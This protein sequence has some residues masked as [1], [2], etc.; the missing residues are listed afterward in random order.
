MS[1][2]RELEQYPVADEARGTPE[3]ELRVVRDA[4][5][6]PIP[7]A[8]GRALLQLAERRLD[9][10][11]S[12]ESLSQRIVDD[13]APEWSDAAV[14][15]LVRQD[16]SV[17]RAGVAA[18]E[19]A[20]ALAPILAQRAADD[21]TREGVSQ[22]LATGLAYAGVV[23]VSPRADE[24]PPTGHDQDG[25]A[26]WHVHV[27][28]LVVR[29]RTVGALSLVSAHRLPVDASTVVREYAR[30]VAPA[31][32]LSRLDALDRDGQ[33][34]NLGPDRRMNLLGD[35]GAL[36]SDGL[37]EAVLLRL[38]AE[39]IVLDSADYCAIELLEPNGTVRVG[40]TVAVRGFPEVEPGRLFSG[41][42]MQPPRSWVTLPVASRGL[43]E[44]TITLASF[45]NELQYGP[46]ELMLVEEIAR[47]VAGAL[48]HARLRRSSQLA[49]LA[50]SDFLSVMS[51][52]LRTPL[53]AILGYAALLREGLA[54]TLTATQARHLSG[55]EN[56]GTHMVAMIDD[57]LSFVGME[58][59]WDVV[60]SG[61]ASV[62]EVVEDVLV[63]TRRLA[64]RK[65]LEVSVMF[66]RNVPPM[67]RM[68][69]A[70]VRRLLGN[71]L[72]NAV[73]FT[74]SGAVTLA[75]SYDPGVLVLAVR[76]SGAGISASQRSQIFEPFWQAEPATTRRVGGVGLGL[77]VA[78]R[79]VTLLG[80][81]LEVD[82]APDGA[83]SVFTAR[84]P[85]QEVNPEQAM[86]GD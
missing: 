24:A 10:S 27:L 61:A 21:V 74:D 53:T 13:I 58:A 20:S 34:L 50:K 73:K 62:H 22:V 85:V 67:V 38:V 56:S 69:S 4:D 9:E 45:R 28:P 16:G 7:A 17:Q 39:R 11:E 79:I 36:V 18:G 46:E 82:N 40:V 2:G 43:V 41:E 54:D 49:Q 77:S 1:I 81:T 57:I 75:V 71:L 76:D 44:G 26:R 5:R 19:D 60:S 48:E 31:L 37:D 78:R 6:R 42:E 68:D 14:L 72:S 64:M 55:I 51:H 63:P 3:V 32:E 25:A 84:L 52:E 30:R 83:G 12:L 33:D 29:S 86:S 23:W 47:R 80:G 15:D 66:A 35:I 65:G 8:R 59:G 70:K